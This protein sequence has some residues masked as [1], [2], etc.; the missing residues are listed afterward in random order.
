[1]APS[2]LLDRSNGRLAVEKTLFMSAF[3]VPNS[4]ARAI[5][6]TSRA[7]R[8]RMYGPNRTPIELGNGR[9]ANEKALFMSAYAV[10]SIASRQNA[11]TACANRRQTGGPNRVP[12]FQHL[13]HGPHPQRLIEHSNAFAQ[14]NK[15]LWP[16]LRAGIGHV[17]RRREVFRRRVRDIRLASRPQTATLGMRRR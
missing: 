7:G 10:P 17:P 6:M 13:R 2:H 1:M 12:I 11:M 14:L 3:A 5:V 15:A 8:R 16:R 9:L 4:A